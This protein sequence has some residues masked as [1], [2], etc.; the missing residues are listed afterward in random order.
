[1][2]VLILIISISENMSIGVG[3]QYFHAKMNKKIMNKGNKE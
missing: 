1:M 2:L 3:V